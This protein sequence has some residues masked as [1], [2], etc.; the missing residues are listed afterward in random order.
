M[1]G[2]R[3]LAYGS[4]AIQCGNPQGRCEVSIGTS[5]GGAFLE[6]NSKLP[7]LLPRNGEQSNCSF[8]PLHWRTVQSPA[9]GERAL[10]I[11][12][13]ELGEFGFQFAHIGCP[14]DT[15]IE[16]SPCFLGHNIGPQARPPCTLKGIL[17]SVPS[18]H[19]VSKVAEQQHGLC[20]VLAQE[21]DL[22][23]IGVFLLPVELDLAS[24]AL[25][26]SR[27]ERAQS[28]NRGL[29]GAGRFHLHDLPQPRQ[30]LGLDA[31][32]RIAGMQRRIGWIP[33]IRIANHSMLNV[34]MSFPF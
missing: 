32:R 20:G 9:N 12:R 22:Q 13:A 19:T 23:V 15:D 2:K 4:Q 11:E 30:H 21:L 18:G 28:I 7:G 14:R 1:R 5:S 26:L 34:T 25:E 33:I 10:R 6:R 3:S 16:S 17:V 8:R 29:V 27:Q 24:A 31:L